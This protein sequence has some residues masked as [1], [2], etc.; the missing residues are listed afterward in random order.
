MRP[1]KDYE[2]RCLPADT[3]ARDSPAAAW[4]L[5]LHQG[6]CLF[7]LLPGNRAVVVD[8]PRALLQAF[9][10]AAGDVAEAFRVVPLGTAERHALAEDPD[11]LFF[12]DFGELKRAVAESTVLIVRRVDKDLS[13][14]LNPT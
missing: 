8:G 12:T 3:I 4:L 7:R 14:I 1:D 2:D 5:F 13:K 6:R 11:C 10:D 9:L